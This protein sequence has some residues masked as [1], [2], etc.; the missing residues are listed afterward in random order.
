LC[1]TRART[2]FPF[3]PL[4]EPPKVILPTVINHVNFARAANEKIP[5]L[6]SV[7]HIR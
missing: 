2:A 4:R 1:T 5:P 6:W 7:R 3:D